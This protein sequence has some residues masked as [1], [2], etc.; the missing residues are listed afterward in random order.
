MGRGYLSKV[1]TDLNQ[2]CR[3]IL[4]V[5]ENAFRFVLPGPFQKKAIRA[6]GLA[7]KVGISG[8]AANQRLHHRLLCNIEFSISYSHQGSSS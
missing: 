5:V 2:P 7:H 1:I 8:G 3:I 4:Q 6:L